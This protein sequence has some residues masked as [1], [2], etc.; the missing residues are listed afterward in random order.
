MAFV[1]ISL[2][3][4]ALVGTGLLL[5]EL[6]ATRRQLQALHA[7]LA[8]APGI[9]TTS[10]API[11]GIEI[12]NPFELAAAENRLAR[13]MVV[14]APGLIRR[15]VY[16]RTVQTILQQ[17]QT[18]GVKASVRIYNGGTSDDLG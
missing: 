14:V 12:L 11:I 6:V 9:V 3:I 10:S 1:V 8:R 15:I 4:V 7:R 18:R 13:P 16:K 2:G 17:L 5:R